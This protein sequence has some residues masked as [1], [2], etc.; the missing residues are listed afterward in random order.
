[1]VGSDANDSLE[2]VITSEKV[3]TEDSSDF[4]CADAPEA[5]SGE[6]AT[7]PSLQ[8]DDFM[9]GYRYLELAICECLRIST[10]KIVSN[11]IR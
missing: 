4:R 10:R 3:L 1:M 8:A 6:K 2:H 11:Y 9:Q 7:C 5:Q